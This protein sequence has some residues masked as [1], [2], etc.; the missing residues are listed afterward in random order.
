[1][2]RVGQADLARR[3]DATN[4]V[5]LNVR[6]KPSY[7]PAWPVG[8]SAIRRADQV[9]MRAILADP[10]AQHRLLRRRRAGRVMG[11]VVLV[12]LWLVP[13]EGWLG[14]CGALAG[15]WRLP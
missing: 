3:T 6:R 12:V 10:V 4:P 13:C 7:R 9:A 15:S 1:M 14:G 5:T 11:H 8:E 2:A